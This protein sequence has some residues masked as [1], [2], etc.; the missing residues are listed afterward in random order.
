MSNHPVRKA[1][2]KTLRNRVGSQV[3][4]LSVMVGT[5]IATYPMMLP[6]PDDETGPNHAASVEK[7]N[8]LYQTLEEQKSDLSEI[9]TKLGFADQN[10]PSVIAGLKTQKNNL[11]SRFNSNAHAF[12]QQV[13]FDGNLSEED[14]YDYMDAFEDNIIDPAT[15]GYA[16]FEGETKTIDMENETDAYAVLRECRIDNVGDMNGLQSCMSEQSNELGWW[17]VLLGLAFGFGLSALGADKRIRQSASQKGFREWEN[18]TRK[19]PFTPAPP[20]H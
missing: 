4:P 2:G 19:T 7:F 20:K 12:V 5:I 13:H 18:G 9:N 6:V 15:I 17:S 10:D 16:D 14:A 1:V 3:L 8:A 11:E